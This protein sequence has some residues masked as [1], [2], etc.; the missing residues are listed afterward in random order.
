[1]RPTTGSLSAGSLGSIPKLSPRIFNSSPSS[2][3]AVS[4]YEE[5]VQWF[6]LFELLEE[7][8]QCYLQPD[9]ISYS[10]AISAFEKGE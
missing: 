1:M 4:V 5:G 3:A 2:S 9:V 7:M 8:Q 10:A 6:L